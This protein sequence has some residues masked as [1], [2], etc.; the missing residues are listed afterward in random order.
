MRDECD[1]PILDLDA[2]QGHKNNKRDKKDQACPWVQ[3]WLL[4]D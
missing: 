2:A 1:P 3:T 4:A